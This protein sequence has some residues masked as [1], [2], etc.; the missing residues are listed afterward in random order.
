MINFISGLA[1]APRFVTLRKGK[2][3]E[4]YLI[5]YSLIALVVVFV[6]FVELVGH[7]VIFKNSPKIQLIFGHPLLRYS[8]RRIGSALISI[9]LAITATFFL[10]RFKKFAYIVR[11][12][13]AYTFGKQTSA[14]PR[15]FNKPFFVLLIDVIHYLIP[16][17]I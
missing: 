17:K 10:I 6:V 14:F 2:H 16:L 5:G 13:S 12:L 1:I 11:I 15:N 8:L 9:L 3:M 4:I 7:K